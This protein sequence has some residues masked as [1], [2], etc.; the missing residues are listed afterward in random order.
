M[1][2]KYFNTYWN[3]LHRTKMGGCDLDS[4]GRGLESGF[5]EHG[6]GPSGL[7]EGREFLVELSGC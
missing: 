6:N 2:P 7:M 5:C 1:L 3:D 4:S